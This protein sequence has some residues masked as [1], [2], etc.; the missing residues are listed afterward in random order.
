[1][2]K[3]A[4]AAM[5]AAEI[6][7]GGKTGDPREAWDLAVREIFPK[8]ESSQLK[9]CPRDSFLTLCELGLVAGAPPSRYTRSVKNRNYVMRAV[10]IL[11]LNP[12]LAN[13]KGALWL[14][15]LNGEKR[16]PNHQMEIV[17]ALTSR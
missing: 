7:S 1:M 13:D 10:E 8:S 15:V 17:L 9:G 5:L 11:R 4:K 16:A 6:L 14:A 2:S 12:S 3:Y